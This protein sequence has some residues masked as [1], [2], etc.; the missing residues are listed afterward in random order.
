MGLFLHR[1]GILKPG[2]PPD[3]TI[4]FTD[5]ATDTLNRST[6]TFSSVGIGTASSDRYIIVAAVGDNKAT[7]LSSSSI[8]PSG[9]SSQSGTTILSHTVAAVASY[10][11]IFGPVTTATT[12]DIE[13]SFNS[14]IFRCGIAVWAATL[15]SDTPTDTGTDQNV[16]NLS[17]NIDIDDGGVVVAVAGGWSFPIF[18]SWVGVDEDVGTTFIENQMRY[19]TASRA[20]ATGGTGTTIGVTASSSRLETFACASFR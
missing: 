17:A 13:L 10:L 3:A 4:A 19:A 18:G 5:N 15:Q 6:Y 9:G 7:A 8:T 14:T 1:S 2:V 12:A 20:Y 16:N 11:A